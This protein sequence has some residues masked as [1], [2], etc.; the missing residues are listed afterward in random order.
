MMMSL[1]PARTIEPRE[2]MRDPESLAI[3]AALEQGPKNEPPAGLFVGG[4]VRNTLLGK[5]VDDIDIATVLR[6]DEVLNCL[7]KAGIRGVPTGID[8]G[9]VTAVM[10]RRNFEITTLRQDVETDGRRAVVAYS[11]SWLEDARRRDFTMNTLLADPSGT[12]F[13]PLGEGIRDLEA[14]E[15]RFVG[16]AAQRIREDYLRILRFFRFHGLYGR[17]E[18]DQDALKACRAAADRISTL[19]R[20]RISQEFFKILMVDKPMDILGMMFENGIL[21]ALRF[22]E[23]SPDLLKGLSFFQ[24]RYGLRA[25]SSRLLAVAGLAPENIEV[26]KQILLIPKVFLK[27]MSAIAGTL[28]LPALEDEQNVKVA[29]YVFGRTCTAQALMIELAQDRVKNAYGS[30][31]LNIIQGWNVPEFPLN[32]EDVMKAKGI[33]AGPELGRLLAMAEARWIENG[34]MP[35]DKNGCLEILKTLF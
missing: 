27:D 1:K 21:T 8:H 3:M 23:F 35:R 20:E 11:E 19:S 16:D 29:V 7:E 24:D 9:T 18:T 28:L 34:F 15:V 6:P 4:C 32:G 30:E 10:Q 17:G 13:D 2:W 33:Q 14:G 22:D 31:A 12:I 25:L 26:M 5:E